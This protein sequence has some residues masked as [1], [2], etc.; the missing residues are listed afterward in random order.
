MARKTSS[1]SRV[2]G[3]ALMRCISACNRRHSSISPSIALS[4]S[5]ILPAEQ[6]RFWC[7]CSEV[8][9]GHCLRRCLATTSIESWKRRQQN[10]IEGWCCCFPQ[11]QVSTWQV[12]MPMA[13]CQA[14]HAS[15]FPQNTYHQWAKVQAASWCG[16]AA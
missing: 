11:H 14:L 3:V 9:A 10:C 5:S 12:C 13:S 2:A 7:Q 15:C 16:H 4:S 1:R 6:A 8:T